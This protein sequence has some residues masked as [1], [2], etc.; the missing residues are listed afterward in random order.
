A[1]VIVAGAAAS[2]PRLA[3]RF[4][5]LGARF[6]SGPPAIG[7]AQVMRGDLDVM[8][9]AR[10]EFKAL[11]S[12]TLTAPTTVTEVKLVKVAQSGRQVKAGDVV[13]EIDGIQEQTRLQ[14]QQSAL[15][16]ADAEIEKTR[17][18]GRI[19]NEQDR[20]DLA[21]AEFDVERARLEV[22]KQEIVSE[23][24]AGKAKLA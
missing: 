12:V 19:Q 24:E 4:S 21:Q 18:Q 2:A 7:T 8:G 14:E 22:S 20:L 6:R 9:K 5:K 10:G 13:I 16:Q 3:P 15:K 23:I 17:A 11:R 1:G